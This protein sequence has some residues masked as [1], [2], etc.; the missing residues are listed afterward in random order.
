MAGVE[1]S[2]TMSLEGL[3]AKLSQSSGYDPIEQARRRTPRGGA[4]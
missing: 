3:Q 4:A 1:T 2:E